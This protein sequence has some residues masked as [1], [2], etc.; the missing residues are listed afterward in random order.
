MPE[1]T[2]SPFH[3]ALTGF[4]L[5]H[6]LSPLIHSAALRACGL[7]GEYLLRPVAPDQIDAELVTIISDLRSGQLHGLNITIP[8]K[9]TI[10]K[11]CDE[12][13]PSAQMIG[14]VN[15]V[16]LQGNKI[17]GDNSDARG[18]M[19][20]LRPYQDLWQSDPRKALVL[21][22]GGSARAVIYA[23]VSSGWEVAVSSRRHEQ[24][25]QLTAA[26]RPAD[27][28]VPPIA[29]PF[30]TDSTFLDNLNLLV[31]TTPLGMS[32]NPAGCPWPTDDPLPVQAIIYDLVYNP[33]ETTLIK[34]ANSQGL[35]TIGGIAML[36][37]QAAIAFECWTGRSAPRDAMYAS[38][39]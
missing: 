10:V 38:V 1:T 18:F 7:E 33:R 8:H 31:N 6:S 17:I 39:K 11:I 24:A 16:S 34:L 14:A 19:A 26:L 5:G 32:P 3:L 27:N 25:E 15:L 37:E 30:P 12:L 28:L 2:S 22:A 13:T 35:Q 23:L 4:P 20:A 29:V 36:V 9:Q 21:G